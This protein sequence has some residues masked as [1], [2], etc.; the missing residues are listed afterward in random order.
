MGVGG[1]KSQRT[2]VVAHV[3]SSPDC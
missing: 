1:T 3:C 2:S